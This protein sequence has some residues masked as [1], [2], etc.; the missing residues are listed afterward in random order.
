MVHMPL[1]PAPG[2]LRVGG[3]PGLQSKSRPA[4]AQTEK[5]CLKQQQK[6]K[7]WKGKKRKSAIL[8]SLKV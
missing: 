2:S 7:K 8:R 1:V 4:R 5:T 6:K 3:Q